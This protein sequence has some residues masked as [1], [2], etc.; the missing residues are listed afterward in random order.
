M[1]GMRHLCGKSVRRVA[2]ARATQMTHMPSLKPLRCSHTYPPF[3]SPSRSPPHFK[4]P[5][6]CRPIA[7][8][9]HRQY[10][11]PDFYEYSNVSGNELP[12]LTF[13][14]NILG[15]FWFA[16]CLQCVR[17]QN[18]RLYRPKAVLGVVWVISLPTLG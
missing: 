8:C 12:T 18:Y 2:D 6:H 4:V 1:G 3:R 9:P 17:M 16:E 11:R 13:P 10:Y 7:G 14:E 15:S 5:E